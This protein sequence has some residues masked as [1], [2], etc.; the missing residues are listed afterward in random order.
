MRIIAKNL[1][2]TIRYGLHRS[3][4]YVHS[5]VFGFKNL[6]LTNALISASMGAAGD[7][8]QQ[9]YDIIMAKLKQDFSS[10]NFENDNLKK[11][12]DGS[13]YQF[14]RTIHL[15]MAGLSTGIVTHYWYLLLVRVFG[16]KRN[17][18]TLIKLILL[19]QIIFSPINLFGMFSVFLFLFLLIIIIFINSLFC[20]VGYL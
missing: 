1:F 2:N 20:N 9:H 6:L 8:I 16:S 19:D 13:R 15:T 14:T 11:E 3:T 4:S 17:P 18:K 7:S 5:V 10:N 12:N